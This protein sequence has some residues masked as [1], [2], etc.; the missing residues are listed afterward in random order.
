MT[1]PSSFLT[2]S[3]CYVTCTVYMHVNHARNSSTCNASQYT[4]AVKLLDK[5]ESPTSVNFFLIICFLTK[6]GGKVTK[7]EQTN[8][9]YM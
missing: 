3:T 5:F 8:S 6:K 4:G 9:S 2:S 1:H 7:E